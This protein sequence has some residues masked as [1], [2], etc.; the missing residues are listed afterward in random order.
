MLSLRQSTGENTIATI[1][2]NTSVP[3]MGVKEVG[4]HWRFNAQSLL[5]MALQKQ[6]SF[7]ILGPVRGY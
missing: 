7:V 3:A 6:S 5:S 2:T 4:F 1:H